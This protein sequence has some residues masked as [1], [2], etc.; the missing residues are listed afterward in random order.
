MAMITIEYE[1]RRAV[2]GGQDGN[3][4][5]LESVETLTPRTK[6][7]EMSDLKLIQAKGYFGYTSVPND[8]ISKL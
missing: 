7:W 2:F 3:W 6:K 1:D 8:F 4:D 5:Y